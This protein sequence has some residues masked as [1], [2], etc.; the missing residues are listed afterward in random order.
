MKKVFNLYLRTICNIMGAIAFLLTSVS[1]ETM[2]W[3]WMYEPEMPAALRP[4]DDD[5]G[6]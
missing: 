1:I 5:M 4:Q 2:S 3:L 6:K